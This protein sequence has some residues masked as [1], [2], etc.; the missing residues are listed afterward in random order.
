MR[1]LKMARIILV[2]GGSSSG[3]TYVTRNVIKNIGEDK[4]THISLD[5][6]YKDL[7]NLTFEERCKVNYDHPKAFDWV[8]IREQIK[9]LKEG[10]AIKKPIYDFTVH[11]RSDQFKIIEPKELIVVEGIM[12]LVDRKLRDMGD[13][14]VFIFASHERRFLRRIVRDRKERGRSFDSIV[15]QYFATVKPMFEEIISPSSTYA[16]VIVNN[17]GRK[18]LAIDVLTVVFKRELEKKGEIELES[19]MDDEFSNDV[20]SKSFTI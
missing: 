12:A 16:D 10:K 15:N 17:D 18:N 7:S 8:L 6:Y 11:N 13:L 4:V 5:D 9:S 20:L 14:K 1:V 3:K 2:G 19:A